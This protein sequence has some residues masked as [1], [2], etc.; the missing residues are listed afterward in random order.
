MTP[1]MDCS[2]ARELLS[3]QLDGSL[4][5]LLARDLEAHLT[6]CAECRALREALG[7][8]VDALKSYPVL[9]P[10]VGLAER[11]AALA[12]AR[13]KAAAARRRWPDLGL[14]VGLQVLA[15]AL[16]LAVTGVV[17]LAAWPGAR[18]KER[19]INAGT[20][21]WER[22]ERVVEDFRFLRVVVSTAFEGRLDK[23]NDRMD[24]YRRLLGKRRATEQEQKRSGPP[25]SDAESVRSARRADFPGNLFLSN[26][27]QVRIVRPIERRQE[28][29]RPR[30]E[31]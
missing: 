20:Y 16:A 30:S 17:L 14:P 28:Q 11:A 23:V 13:P 15:A 4:D 22:K 29:W 12:L 3:D 27:A 24:D 8:V 2:R 26:R 25:K 18:V 7:E 6:E 1:A 19:T 21:L 10:P 31:A 9:E 5:P